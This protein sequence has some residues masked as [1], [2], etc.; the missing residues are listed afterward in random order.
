M[1]GL[2]NTMT[3][4]NLPNSMQNK[5]CGRCGLIGHI[6][7]ICK[8]E[9]YCR[10]CKAYTHGTTACRT[11]PVTSSRKNTPEKRTV[12]DIEHE[13]SRRV[14][15]EIQRILNDLSTS[16][17]VV[18]TQ[19]VPQTNQNAER[20][21]VTNQT[22]GQH[23]Q[24]LIGDFQCPPEVFEGATRNS[25]RM[26]GIGDQILNQQW[27]K[28][29]HMQPPMIP[30][31]APTP[32]AEYTATSTTSRK[33]EM[34]AERQQVN[35][36]KGRLGDL[37]AVAK[38]KAS[39]STTNRQ[40]ETL[41]GNPQESQF[42]S[43]QGNMS[44]PTGHRRP[45]QCPCCSK[46]TK[47]S[48]GQEN[49]PTTIGKRSSHMGCEDPIANEVTSGCETTKGSTRGLQECKVIRVLP[50]EELDFMDLVRD[51]VS[52]QAKN[53]SKPMFVNNYF[54]G[55]N[56]WRTTARETPYEVRTTR[57]I[58]EL[59]FHSGTDRSFPSRR[60]KQASAIHTNRYFKDESNE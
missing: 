55:N 46:L 28:P 7:R 58:E 30:T 21:N 15:E 35:L 38:E 17:R 57:R 45:E 54:V 42:F 50:D 60:G 10:Y 53:G 40:V 3:Y 2:Q 59:I 27:D 18:N 37:T 5:I 36:S 41:Q 34:K 22:L 39:I 20:K 16:R 13:V 31:I 1:Q 43:V 12:E 32:Q 49:W 19:H 6:K 8:E 11:Y 24:N 56:N 9:V 23:A 33:V 26:E 25:N 51:S 14:Q 29:P 44:T 52:A 4:M 47:G 48:P